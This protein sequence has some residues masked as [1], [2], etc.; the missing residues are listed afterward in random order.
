V[1]IASHRRRTREQSDSSWLRETGASYSGKLIMAL[2][3]ST[4]S[5]TRV[6]AIALS[7]WMAAAACVIGCM[8]PVLARSEPS[9][10]K[11]RLPKRSQSGLMADM[12]CCHHEGPSAPANGDKRSPHDSVSCCPLDARVTPTQKL[13]AAPLASAFESNAILSLEFRFAF[14]AFS[15]PLA[16]AHAFWHSGRETLLKARVLRI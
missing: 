8:Q 14:A 3:R 10:S 2:M 9:M 6:L 1:T 7:F 16:F 12:D 11:P 15:Y 13:N 5:T 4:P